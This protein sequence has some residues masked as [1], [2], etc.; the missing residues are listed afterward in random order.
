MR[1]LATAALLALLFGCDDDSGALGDAAHDS[2]ADVHVADV[3]PDGAVPPADAGLDSAEPPA[4]ARADDAAPDVALDMAPDDALDMAPDDA[5]DM[6]PDASLDMAPDVAL[7]G[8]PDIAPDAAPDMAP[9]VAP[10][11]APDVAPDMAPDAAPDMAPPCDPGEP[12]S[13]RLPHVGGVVAFNELLVEPAGDRDAEW[14]ELHNQLAVDLDLSGWRIEG[15]VEFTVPDGTFLPS[16]GYLVVALAPDR[17][18]DGEALGPYEGRLSNGGERLRLRNNGGRLMDEV[19]YDDVHPW[20][21]LAEGEGRSIAK[22]DPERASPPAEHW[23]PS[24]APG[25]TPGRRNFPRDDA[26]A[27]ELI[28]LG[29]D[30]RYAVDP[31]DGWTAVA[32]DDAG[33]A[34]G[35]GPLHAGP[36][37]PQPVSVR[38]SADEFVAVYAGGA[39]GSNM[40]QVSRGAVGDW[41]VPV[42]FDV[43][44]VPGERVYLL[45]WEAPGA[46]GGPQMVVGQF[47]AGRE[48]VFGTSAVTMEF[49]LGAMGAAGDAP[50][51]AVDLAEAVVDATDRDAWELPSGQLPIDAAPW[52]DTLAP[53]FEIADYIWTDHFEAVSETNELATWALFR[54][55]VTPT[56]PG[57]AGGTELPDGVARVGFRRAFDFDGDP[58]TAELVLDARSDDALV[59]YLNGVEVHRQ[60]AAAPPV[61]L[62]APPLRPGRNVLAV[63]VREAVDDARLSFDATLRTVARLGDAPPAPVHQAGEV[64]INELMYNAYDDT[65]DWVELHNPGD[66]PVDLGGWQLVDAVAHRIP[67]GTVLEA[68][69]YLVVDDFDGGLANRGERLELR[70][71]CGETVDEV[72]WYDGGRWPEWAD[73]AGAS[74]ELRNPAADN[75]SPDAWAASDEAAR[76]EWV[77]VRYRGVAEPSGLGPDG[78]WHELVIGMLTAGEV[79][80]DDVSVVEDPDG[81]AVELIQD[82]GFD[83][84]DAS[85][86]RLIGTH[87]HSEVIVDPD[88]PDNSVL[89]VVASGAHTDKHNHIET[90]YAERRE[91]QNGTEYEI[92]YRARWIGGA[93]LVNTRLYFTRL[94]RS[95]RIGP[96]VPGGT[97]GARNSTYVAN[98][99]PTFAP[100]PAALRHFPAVPAAGQ[101]IEFVAQAADP[102][103]VASMT[104]WWAVDGAPFEAAPMALDALGR[105]RATLR[106]HDAGTLLRMYVEATDGLGASATFPARGPEARAN[107]KVDSDRGSDGSLR[108]LRLWQTA[109]DNAFLHDLIEL[110]SNDGGRATVVYDDRTVFYDVPV[111]LKGSQAG[112]PTQARR[113]FHVRFPADQRLRDVYGSA[114]IDRSEVAVG[115]GQREMLANVVMQRGGSV[116]AEYNDLA[117]LVPSRPVFTGPVE[118]QLARFGDLLLANQWPSGGDGHVFEYENI[119]IPTS[120]VDGDPE[121]RKPPVPRRVMR[122]RLLYLGEDPEAYRFQYE[123][124]NNRTRE[125]FSGLVAFLQVMSMPDP[126]YRANIDRVMDVDSWLRQ[127]AFAVIIGAVDSYATES[128]HNAQLYVRPQD[129]RVLFFPHDL[130]FYRGPHLPVVANQDLRRLVAIP[131]N[132]RVYYGH[133]HD[134]L[135]TA[136]NDDYMSYWRDHFGALLPEQNF[137]GH[138]DFIVARAA[139]IRSE[140]PGSIQATFPVVNFAITTNGGADFE[141]D[142][143]VAEVEGSGWIDVRRITAGGA[144]LPVE[145]IDDATWRVRVPLAPGRNAVELTALDHHGD[146]V[147]ADAVT[148]TRIEPPP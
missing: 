79:W 86:W 32:F 17:L 122:S 110:M 104:L 95:T 88:D 136:F 14:L 107:V 142:A 45:G 54:T 96:V 26:P 102:D 75:T 9:D 8:A 51:S 72:R 47:R 145:W 49:T 84:P 76:S 67:A 134:I 23:R 92:A 78:Q 141:A 119:N 33:W 90:T 20:P 91:I 42:D 81:A 3:A 108:N 19:E 27:S 126:E 94:A 64:V 2:M 7:D 35:P 55:R 58:A 40:R 37:G 43:G 113:G 34:A 97:P 70:D 128:T 106:G 143:E 120:T 36:P 109:E 31:A 99:A 41:T 116:S 82:G 61:T 4:D 18:P 16:G 148:V 89:R 59:V 44:L 77:E 71:A 52:G 66:A 15:G 13:R 74:L 73:G 111:R 118:M 130:D 132:R 6:A 65:A 101:P 62:A 114:S 68:G 137:A 131:G 139:W 144:A 115:T 140:A 117:Y 39:D 60:G 25:G 30:W 124:K 138:H 5:L 98:P 133:L 129:Q 50:L 46:D 38:V 121:S 48:A 22:A 112:R 123:V 29:D 103:G 83:D 69:G 11:M 21:E 146:Q 1:R 53:L 12:W 147:G 63:E 56:G 93:G 135:E 100:S 105:Y 87:R 80:L 24:I 57:D 28:R 10:D 125:D 127:V 85:T